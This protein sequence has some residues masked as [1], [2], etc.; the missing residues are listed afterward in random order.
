MNKKLIVIS[1]DAMVYEDLETLKNLP[2]FRWMLE[3]GAR[4]NRVRSIYPTLTY[5]CHTTM[6]T[7]LY[8]EHH[9]I[10]NNTVER[11]GQ[12]ELPWQFY[13]SAARGKDIF[14]AC[15]EV[16]MTTAAV[17][18]PVTGNHPNI[19]W[20]VDEV[21]PEKPYT[22]ETFAQAYRDSG[23]SEEVF[24]EIVAPI[25]WQRVPRRNPDSSY[26]NCRCA[27][28]IIR[29]YQP[30]LLM[31]H[32]GNIDA[33]RHSTGVFS[34]DVTLGLLQCDQLLG[35]LIE[36]TRDA[37]VFEQTNF[38]VTAD[39]GQ[40]NITRLVKPNT[41]FVKEG[42]VTLNDDGSVADWKAWCYSAG[43]SAYVVLKDP[44]D[45]ALQAQVAEL[46]RKMCAEGVWGFSEVYTR[47]Q[48]KEQE[49]LDGPFTFMLETD[50][51][52]KFANGW[53]GSYVQPL[54]METDGVH[55][56]SHGFHPDKGPRPLLLGCGPDFIKGAVLEQAN[57]TD[58]APTYAELLRVSLPDADGRALTDILNG[59][60]CVTD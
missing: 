51:Y 18:W 19:D 1:M 53:Q 17:G 30:D 27:C 15:K 47:E 56:A 44:T 13:K 25:L 28:G 6:A 34:K 42:L 14:D 5:P 31:L 35:M 26:F 16:G 22:W 55:K 24:R 33:Y 52:S 57:L 40:L 48:I 7:G 46:L 23:T 36:A 38:V 58:G 59:V 60:P 37:G 4:V 21:W 45:A 54:P 39:H 12:E 11:V 29:R 9:G 49:H 2:N 3:N 10:L 50:G 32:T 8:P 41:V 20:L 43:L